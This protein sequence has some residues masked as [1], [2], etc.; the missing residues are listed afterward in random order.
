MKILTN[1]GKNPMYLRLRGAEPRRLM[2]EGG[3]SAPCGDDE[4]NALLE[5]RWGR[6]MQGAGLLAVSDA[7]AKGGGEKADDVDK[8]SKPQGKGKSAKAK[9]GG[10][11]Q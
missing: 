4:A 5:T 3:S 7:K 9:G 1:K 11:K 8:S 10:E 2:L 6:R